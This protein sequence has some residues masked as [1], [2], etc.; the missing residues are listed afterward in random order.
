LWSGAREDAAIFS[1][2][3]VYIA[4]AAMILCNSDL[5][6]AGFA[7]TM[8]FHEGPAVEAAN[9]IYYCFCSE[10]RIL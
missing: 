2:L 9:G 10:L 6:A 8:V 7:A 1:P 5:A 4:E 3:M